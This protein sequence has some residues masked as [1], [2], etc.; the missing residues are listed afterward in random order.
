VITQEVREEDQRE[1][2]GKWFFKDKL[3]FSR[4]VHRVSLRVHRRRPFVCSGAEQTKHFLSPCPLR[5]L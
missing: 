5:A 2:G 3:F 4:R 1:V